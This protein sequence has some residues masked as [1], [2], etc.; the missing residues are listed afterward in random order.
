MARSPV[1]TVKPTVPSAPEL[2]A[3]RKLFYDSCLLGCHGIVV[4]NVQEALAELLE[5]LGRP[6]LAERS[7][8]LSL[9]TV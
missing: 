5:R 9:L 1:K 3:L 6:D 8:D 7:R 4:T 2:A